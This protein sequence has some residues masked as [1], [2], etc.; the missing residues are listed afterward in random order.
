MAQVKQDSIQE[1]RIA[2]GLQHT[3]GSGGYDAITYE[4]CDG[5]R[6]LPNLTQAVEGRLRTRAPTNAEVLNYVIPVVSISRRFKIHH[7]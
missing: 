5:V 3:D 7:Q 6:H 4:Q 2:E 1:P